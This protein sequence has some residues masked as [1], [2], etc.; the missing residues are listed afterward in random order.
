MLEELFCY[1]M[2]ITLAKG[3]NAIC[4]NGDIH[5]FKLWHIFAFCFIL[6]TGYFLMWQYVWG[7]R[8]WHR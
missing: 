7:T 4:M 3:Y 2:N 6:I 5:T 1:K 8:T